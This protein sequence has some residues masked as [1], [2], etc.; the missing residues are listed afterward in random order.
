[1]SVATLGLSQKVM[2][3]PGKVA[4]ASAPPPPPQVY[5][6]QGTGLDQVV[7]EPSGVFSDHLTPVHLHLVRPVLKAGA[8]THTCAHRHAHSEAHPRICGA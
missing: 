6:V 8:H 7:C 3:V 2:L 4:L 5:R 1:M